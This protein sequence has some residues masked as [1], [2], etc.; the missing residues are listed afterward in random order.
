MLIDTML[1]RADLLIALKRILH[2]M[3]IS[4]EEV[5]EDMVEYSQLSNS[6][7][8]ETIARLHI[9]LQL[10]SVINIFDC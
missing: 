6:E 1:G 4:R 2:T 7:L 8:D 3:G 5:A 10:G 9:S